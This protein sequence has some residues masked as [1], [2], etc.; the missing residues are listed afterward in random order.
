MKIGWDQSMKGPEWFPW[1]EHQQVQLP[2]AWLKSL[3]PSTGRQKAQPIAFYA[4]AVWALH[5]EISRGSS[6]RKAL[7]CTILP[8]PSPPRQEDVKREGVKGGNVRSQHHILQPLR[9]IIAMCV[10][11]TRPWQIARD[12]PLWFRNAW[13]QWGICKRLPIPNKYFVNIFPSTEK[14]STRKCYFPLRMSLIWNSTS[15][16]FAVM[17]KSNKTSPYKYETNQ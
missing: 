12:P 11:I 14:K 16:L 15:V 17:Y 4:L 9:R 13:N 8:L 3:L 2:K 1:R 5:S 10:S 6:S 7:T